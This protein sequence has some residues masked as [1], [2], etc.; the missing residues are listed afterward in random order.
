MN[1]NTIANVVYIGISGNQSK[2]QIYLML[3]T[4]LF[5]GQSK[6]ALG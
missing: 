1:T 4:P 6:L 3:R 2:Y 5:H